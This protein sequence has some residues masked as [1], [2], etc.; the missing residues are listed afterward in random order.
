MRTQ[1]D[2]LS[3]KLSKMSKVELLAYLK[4]KRIEGGIKPSA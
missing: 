1:R 2:S 4:K 3:E